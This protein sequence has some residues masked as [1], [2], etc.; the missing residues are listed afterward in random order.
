MIDDIR[1]EIAARIA[2]AYVACPATG[3]MSLGNIAEN[4]VSIADILIAQ[5]KRPDLANHAVR[6][7]YKGDDCCWYCGTREKTD[8]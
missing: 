1:T 3:Q 5:L 4:S 2:A 7:S 8:E 6:L